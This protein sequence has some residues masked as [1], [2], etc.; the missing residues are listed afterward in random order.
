MSPDTCPLWVVTAYYNPAR[1]R[2]RLENF[3][4][5]SRHLN[6]P[7]LV[8]E[9]ANHGQHQLEHASCDRLIQLTGESH[10][11]QKER[12]LNIGI[13][14]L[15]AH[16][17]Y[18][19]WIDCDVVF[20]N[21][22]WLEQAVSH[23]ETHGGFLQ[24]FESVIH[25][26]QQLH[27]AEHGSWFWLDKEALLREVSGASVA[28]R[29]NYVIP[30]NLFAR[31]HHG[32]KKPMSAS[33]EE[34]PGHAWAA[35]ISGVLEAGIYDGN[36]IGGGD[37]ILFHSAAGTLEHLLDSR[38]CS[39]SHQSHIRTWKER[40]ASAGLLDALGFIEGD[41]LHFWHGDFA[42]RRYRQRHQIL[43]DA[44]YDPALDIRLAENL[45]WTWNDPRGYL[46]K[47]VRN[48]F[49]SRQEDGAPKSIKCGEDQGDA[50]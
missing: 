50:A 19:A 36:I 48:Y 40:A 34:S 10:I 42:N 37:S 20:E 43:F 16:V 2:R 21:T 35:R 29:G 45:T 46:A 14:A 1:Y 49:H 17:K 41:L 28:A 22:R 47:A 13:A 38:H 12:L 3:H 30:A 18:V 9:L 4:A 31:E 11:W 26:P 5:F 27:P 7:L 24:L 25:L 32:Q 6:A 33:L 39:P 15:P 8:V 44:G 23:L